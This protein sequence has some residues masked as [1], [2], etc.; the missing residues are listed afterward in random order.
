MKKFIYII[1]VTLI[2]TIT[3][4]AYSQGEVESL[5]PEL[6]GLLKQEMLAIQDGMKNI[7]P[8]FVSGNLQTVAQIAG[9]INKS[10]ILKQKITSAQ[11]HELHKK[12]PKG[13]IQKDQQFH[14][15]AGMLQ[16]VSEENHVELVS[17]YYSKMMDSC[18]GCHTEYA[19]HRFPSLKSEAIKEAHSH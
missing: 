7:V 18:I 15:Y 3:S 10:Y 11:K 2:A 16:H 14:K 4:N 12:L 8:A 19:T 9:N 5:S 6:R 17:F 13:F 1:T